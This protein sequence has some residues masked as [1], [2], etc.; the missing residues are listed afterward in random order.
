AIYPVLK[1]VRAHDSV[2]GHAALRMPHQPE[3][4]YVLFA[5]LLDDEVDDVLQVFVVGSRPR[6]GR[7]VRR[8]DHQPIFVLVVHDREVV[9]LPVTVR[10]S[11]VQAKHE[12]DLLVLLK[13]ARIVEEISAPRLH[14]DYV[15]LVYDNSP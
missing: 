2:G 15:S 4:L 13:I 12:S 10:S 3:R 14:L 5:D 8:G 11:A 7:G 6:P 9:T 1:E